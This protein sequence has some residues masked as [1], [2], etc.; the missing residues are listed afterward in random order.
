MGPGPGVGRE[1]PPPRLLQPQDENAKAV[2]DI[3]DL[4]RILKAIEQ[5]VAS[6]AEKPL[7]FA[8]LATALEDHPA[9]WEYL[10]S[11]NGRLLFI[12]VAPKEDE[13]QLD[14]LED[15]LI[16]IRRIVADVAAKHPA[17]Q[18]GIT[19][20]EVMDA[21]ETQ[22]NTWDSTWTSILATVLITSASG[23]GLPQLAHAAA[24]QTVL[25]STASP[26]P[27]AAPLFLV[28]GHLQIL[29]V[30]FNVMLLGLGIAY[31]I[32]LASAF[33]LIRH[34]YPDDIEGFHQTLA[35]TLEMMGPGIATGSLATAAAF[36]V[37]IFTDFAGVAEMGKISGMGILLCFL[38]M[39]TVF[40]VFLRLFKPSH[41]HITPLEDRWAWS[42]SSPGPWAMPFVRH[43]SSR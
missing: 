3:Q 30:V 12:R 1:K 43:P 41:K 28:V 4:D 35:R 32:Y 34:D 24:G 38:A 2:A 36:A 39:F 42:S 40:P 21:E 14:P 10:P 26:G 20:L 7:D 23:P 33:E 27:M 13:T 15:S 37:T 8:S 29:S 22:V 19:G 6:P 25:S 17:V 5:Y 9:T 31:G 18:A 11:E 16:A